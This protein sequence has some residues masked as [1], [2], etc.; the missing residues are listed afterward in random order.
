[1]EIL[2]NSYYHQGVKKL[3]QRFMPM[4]FAPDSLVEGFYDPDTYN[5]AEVYTAMP[6][7][8]RS[9]QINVVLDSIGVSIWQVVVE[10]CNMSQ[11]HR[12]LPKKSETDHVN[13]TNSASSDSEISDGEEDD[14]SIVIYVDNCSETSRFAFGCDDGCV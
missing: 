13:L 1:M 5:P 4:E 12:N 2:V 14:N 7:G 10:P 8:I 9:S 6:S 3:S 11:L